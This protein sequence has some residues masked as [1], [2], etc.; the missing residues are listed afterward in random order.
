[1]RHIPSTK[2]AYTPLSFFSS[3]HLCSLRL[4]NTVCFSISHRTLVANLYI[5]SVFVID[6]RKVK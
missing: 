3:E 5:F 6:F 2:A 1:M 4:Q